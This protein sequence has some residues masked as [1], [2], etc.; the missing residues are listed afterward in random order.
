MNE[1]ETISVP[2]NQGGTALQ[3]QSEKKKKKRKIT[4]SYWFGDNS[5]WGKCTRKIRFIV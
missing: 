2:T 1:V 4:I 5:G 3:E